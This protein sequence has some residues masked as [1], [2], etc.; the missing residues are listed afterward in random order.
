VVAGKAGTADGRLAKRLGPARGLFAFHPDRPGPDRAWKG[1]IMASNSPLLTEEAILATAED[2][3]TLLNAEHGGCATDA[4]L[5]K[6]LVALGHPEP[7]ARIALDYLIACGPVRRFFPHGEIVSDEARRLKQLFPHGETVCDGATGC[8]VFYEYIPPL[9]DGRFWV[10]TTVFHHPWY[11]PARGVKAEAGEGVGGQTAPVGQAKRRR[12]AD[13]NQQ[14]KRIA[15]REQEKADKRLWE[16]WADGHGQYRNLAELARA[17]STSDRPLTAVDVR[18]GLDRHR[19]R[20]E[21]SGKRKS[22]KRPQ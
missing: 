11:Q 6:K 21:R 10:K 4:T 16:V 5:V 2:A 12:K 19:K 8:E 3:L 15:K 13:P 14:A 7:L 20:L 9:E 17:V 1:E 18:K 22:D